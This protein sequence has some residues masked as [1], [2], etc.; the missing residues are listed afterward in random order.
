MSDKTEL[1]EYQEWVNS[2]S[3]RRGVTWATVG[4]TSEAG[5]VAGEIEKWL[6]KDYG[7]PAPKDAIFDELGDVLWYVAEICNSL[8]ISLDEV[9][10]HNISKTN[11]RVYDE[12]HN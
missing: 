11:Q 3:A 2:V 9:I 1:T 4:L 6:R 5:E 7:L 12:R 10:E 8:D